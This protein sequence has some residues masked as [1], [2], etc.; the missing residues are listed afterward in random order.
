MTK[1]EKIEPPFPRIS[2]DDAVK[3]LQEGHA[4][5][6]WN[7]NSNTAETSALPTKPTCHR[8]TTSRSWCIAIPRA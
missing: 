3:A 2:Y 1:L 7:T 5:A 6:S 8:S 4:K